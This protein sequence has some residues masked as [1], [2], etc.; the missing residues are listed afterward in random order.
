MRQYRT[1]ADA[2]L[3][4]IR[5]YQHHRARP[6]VAALALRRL[7]RA[8]HWVLSKLTGSDIDIAVR[9]G[10]NL[11]LPHPNGVVF[12]SQVVIGDD[13]MVMQQVTLGQLASGDLPVIGSGVYI[14]AGAKVLGP[15]TIGDGAQI[16][17]NAVVLADVPAGATAVGVPAKL[18]VKKAPDATR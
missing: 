17:A 14:G 2:L 3:D 18:V 13:C 5:R 6:G 12:H 15:V 7:A 10:R 9:F 4:C 16:G 8:E 1:L 11:R